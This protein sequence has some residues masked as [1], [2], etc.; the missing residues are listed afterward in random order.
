MFLGSYCQSFIVYHLLSI[1]H[2]LISIV[3]SA[4]PRKYLPAVVDRLY[5]GLSL[6]C[7]QLFLGS[8]LVGLAV[9]ILDMSQ[10]SLTT[11]DLPL[12]S[13]IP[14]SRDSYCLSAIV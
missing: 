8:L 4:V 13:G 11:D 7:L 1:V 5:L 3:L 9:W 14:V 2:H 6:S 12:A 10:H